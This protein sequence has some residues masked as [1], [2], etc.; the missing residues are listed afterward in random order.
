MQKYNKA[1]IKY[2]FQEEEQ[3]IPVERLSIGICT[4][5]H[6]KDGVDKIC[7]GPDRITDSGLDHRPDH[8]QGHG[9]DRGPDHE[10][11]HG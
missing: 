1:K 2:S 6:A 9:L 11:D 8:R 7:T 5:R 4:W 10:P 3:N